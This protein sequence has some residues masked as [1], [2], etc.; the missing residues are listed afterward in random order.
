MAVA[1]PIDLHWFSAWV[2]PRLPIIVATQNDPFLPHRPLRTG[3]NSITPLRGRG[4]HQSQPL[5][6]YPPETALALGRFVAGSSARAKA[7]RIGIV[8]EKE[9]AAERRERAR[10]LRGQ[11]QTVRLLGREIPVL[12]APDGTL[13]AGDH[14]KP[15][16]A[17]SVAA[18]IARAFG[19][20]LAEARAAM[21]HLAASQ[22]ADDLKQV[23][24]QL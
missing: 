19:G 1:E 3:R 9:E 11:R 10:E 23:R 22:P 8:E 13:R 6:Q 15:S 14:G 12:P 7:R 18:Y 2:P 5:G 20:R 4:G 21:E 17:K 24:F 16:S